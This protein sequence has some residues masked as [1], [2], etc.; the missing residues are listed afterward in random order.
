M[1]NWKRVLR[2]VVEDLQFAARFLI[3]LTGRVGVSLTG[4]SLS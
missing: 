2:I 3:S 4:S 1:G